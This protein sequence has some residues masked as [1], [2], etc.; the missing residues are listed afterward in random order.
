MEDSRFELLQQAFHSGSVTGLDVCVRRPL[1]VS[2]GNDK[3]IRLWNYAENS[4]ELVKFFTDEIYSI[5]IHPSGLYLVV[6]F[7]DKLR[8]MT[9]L[10]DDFRTYKEFNIRNCKEASHFY[11]LST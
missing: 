2:C 6:G 3:S 7:A 10:I 5:S 4:C 1:I 9:V 11:K 8:L